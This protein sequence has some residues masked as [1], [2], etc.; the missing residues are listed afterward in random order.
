VV[1]WSELKQGW[2]AVVGAVAM[3]SGDAMAAERVWNQGKAKA[4]IS[5][6]L[7]V[8]KKKNRSWNRIPWRTSAGNAANEARETGRPILVFF[9][10][11]QSGPP[12]ERCCLE[13]RLLR[14]HVLSNSTVLSLI[15]A[16]YIPVKV[17]LQRGKNFPLTWPAL[18]RW[19]T[20][21]KFVDG[22]GFAGCSVVSA[23]LQI[24]YC[25]SGSARLWELFDSRAYDA[26]KFAGQLERAASR[27]T[28]ERSLRVQRGISDFERQRELQSFRR[29]VVKA[30]RSE[31]NSRLPPR[32]Y[33]LE[34]AVE[35][36][37]MAGVQRK[38]AG[39]K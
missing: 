11:E 35:L 24:E 16:N 7:A 27:V 5:Q 30:V 1:V 14:T 26:K 28:E 12:L 9:F 34:Q 6:V 20:A 32:G 29:G 37:Q 15:K 8:E 33:S 19:A 21:F 38:T 31:N 17:K 3:S 18:K 10:V 4:M 36:L 13:G 39:T 2:L 22:S 25:N 23:D